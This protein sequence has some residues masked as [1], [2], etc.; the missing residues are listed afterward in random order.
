MWMFVNIFILHISMIESKRAKTANVQ[1]IT[2]MGATE[3]S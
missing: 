3:S 1:Y 2:K